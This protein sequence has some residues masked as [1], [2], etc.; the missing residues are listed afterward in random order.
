MELS[1]LVG[2]RRRPPLLATLP[3]IPPQ[4]RGIAEDGIFYRLT[5]AVDC[6]IMSPTLA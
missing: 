5:P 2:M 4:M 1:Y 3:L 6:W